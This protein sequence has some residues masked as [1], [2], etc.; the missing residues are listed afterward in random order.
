MKKRIFASLLCCALLF[1]GVSPVSQAADYDFSSDMPDV[2]QGDGLYITVT[3]W[4]IKN[5][6]EGWNAKPEKY[7]HTFGETGFIEGY[8]PVMRTGILTDDHGYEVGEID[9]LNYVDKNGNLLDLS[10]F[11]TPPTRIPR[12]S[13]YFSEGLCLYY[14]DTTGLFGYMDTQGSLVIEPQ[15]KLAQPFHDGVAWTIRE[16]D[17]E[18]K[19]VSFIDHSGN[20]VL[21]LPG[22]HL[23]V[24]R[25]FSHGLVP[26]SGTL[27]GKYFVGYL[28]KQ[29]KPAITLFRGDL[30]DYD[31]DQYLQ[32]DVIAD[33]MFD[34][35]ST[36]SEDGYAL[37]IDSRG[38]R[39]YPCYVV[40]DTKGNQVGVIDVD[41]PQYLKL[42]HGIKDG[43][44]AGVEIQGNGPLETGQGAVF[45]IYGNQVL[46]AG[47]TLGT[48]FD[49]G[50][51]AAYSH[52][53]RTPLVLDTRGN[54]VIPPLNPSNGYTHPYADLYDFHD[55][56]AFMCV[57]VSHT[58]TDF[59]LL[60]VHQGT[61]TGSGQV[62]NSVTGQL[63]GGGTTPTEPTDP[64]TDA[65][66]SWAAEQVNQA[67]SAGIVPDSLQSQYTQPTT[68]AQFCALA[69]E[70]YETVKGAEITE[71]TTF[72][73]TTDVNVQKMGALGIVTGV[74]GG[75]FNPGGTLT[76]EQAA[77]MLSR[78]AEAVGKPL[79]AQAPTFADNGSV[80]SWAFD[81]VGRMQA[82][83]IM[84]G[85]G[86]NTL[87]P[88]GSYSREQSIITM[89]RLYEAVK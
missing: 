78:L 56:V 20:T 6:Q 24:G 84:G 68:R 51:I 29:G 60:E 13:F 83:G 28:D 69:V 52:D 16:E 3:P 8:M 58:E 30:R 36:F 35:S 49:S 89:L 72:T 27:D 2:F 46:P 41:P 55:G 44:I 73:D 18:S 63:T 71:R 59:Y 62:Y 31:L 47:S 50:V 39:R 81:A 4:E 67:I 32:V 38:G 48:F 34:F 11:E 57:N 1:V 7:V 65:P 87:A 23:N 21:C 25:Y 9:Y 74:G 64:G 61:Y 45:D 53:S 17:Y 79:P 5:N 54:V 77:T 70:L 14:D 82:S 26:F 86:S 10:H 37:L 75:K 76:R 42:Y 88:Q 40:I 43:L 80:S 19:S 22:A 85:V 66:S 12:T 15:F 33:S